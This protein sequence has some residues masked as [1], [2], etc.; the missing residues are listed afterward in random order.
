MIKIGPAG[1]GGFK[2]TEEFLER[3]QKL[4]I[5]CAEIPFTYRVWLDNE[6]SKKVGEF[7]KKFNIELTIHAP[8]Y[9][10]LDSED[11]KKI[12]DSM[13]R[14]LDCCEKANFLGAKY[15]VF[16]AAYYGKNDP[17]KVFQIVKKKIL[18]MQ[19]IIKKNNWQVTLA[20]ETTGKK[21]QFGSLDELI[22]LVKETK[23][24]LCIDF[25]HLEARNGSIDYDKILTK[26]NKAKLGKL[27]CHFSG[28]VYSDK[29]ERNHEITPDKKWQEL[30]KNLKKYKIECNII[31]ESP[32]PIEDSLKGLK[33]LDKLK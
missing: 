5:G 3:Y 33:I 2:E 14:I 29:G 32:T 11:P 20:P 4:G 6:Q 15:V 8:Y 23:C 10:N 31:N 12:Q 26:I 27:H 22:Q 9:I 17:K 19:K 7:A 30:L 18:E 21:S 13:R 28:I 1:I 16:H 24:F 25:A